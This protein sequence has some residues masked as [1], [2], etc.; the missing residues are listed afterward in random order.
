MIWKEK[1][2]RSM[3]FRFTNS[4][5]KKVLNLELILKKN[6]PLIENYEDLKNRKLLQFTINGNEFSA[7]NTKRFSWKRLSE[8]AAL[9]YWTEEVTPSLIT[10]KDVYPNASEKKPESEIKNA[11]GFYESREDIKNETKRRHSTPRINIREIEKF[12][13]IICYGSFAGIDDVMLAQGLL[14]LYGSPSDEIIIQYS[15]Q[16]KNRHK[17]THPKDNSQ[18]VEPNQEDFQ[19]IGLNTI[20]YGPPGTGKTYEVKT[21]KDTLLLN[22]SASERL[23]NFEGL[24]WRE[25]IYLAYNLDSQKIITWS[26]AQHLRCYIIATASS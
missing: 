17:R 3:L 23:Y 22:Q 7:E 19:I 5:R 18:K 16:Q 6:K 24:S 20:L 21:Y 15:E 2:F 9:Q 11:I 8:E 10:I 26:G 12:G 14:N 25:A 4:Q 13:E 1:D